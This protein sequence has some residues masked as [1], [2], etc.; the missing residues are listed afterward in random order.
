MT[1]PSHKLEQR[2]FRNGYKSICAVDEVGVGCLA[3]PV[4]ACTVRIKKPFLKQKNILK[5]VRDSKLLTPRQREKL[6]AQLINNR[7]ITHSISYSL[8]RT[9]DKYNIYNA[10]RNTMKRSAQNIISLNSVLL[11][12]G[13]RE[14]KNMHLPQQ[15][16]IKGDRKVIVIA[17]ASVIA[18]VHRDR[19]MKRYAKRY[20]GYGLE[21]HKGYGT[22]YHI[23]QLASLGPSKI[24]RK[25]F[26]PV[27]RL[28]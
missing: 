10:S 4:V 20:P 15:A 17:C 7:Y 28:L 3:G 9:I 1:L 13:P 12:D 27:A 5:N 16:I 8:P 14:L 2:L 22:K 19:M 24:H 18:K 21:Q 11:V 23:A 26:A 25:S 6:Y